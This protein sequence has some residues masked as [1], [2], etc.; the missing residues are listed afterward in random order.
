MP[1]RPIHAVANGRSSFFYCWIPFHWIY[2]PHLLCLFIPQWT[3]RLYVLLLW[4]VQQWTWAYRYHSQKWNCWI[5]I[6]LFSLFWGNSTLFPL[7]A[8]P[9][10][11]PTNSVHTRFPFSPYPHQNLF[12][13]VFFFFMIAIL[14]GVRWYLLWFW[15]AFPWWLMMLST[16]PVNWEFRLFYRDVCWW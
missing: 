2:T 9:I 4:T 6:V 5:T 13:P 10:Y 12:S 8:A 1:S 11:I 3:L 16:F 14:T 7:V 15:F